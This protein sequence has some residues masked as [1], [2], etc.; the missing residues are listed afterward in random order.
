MA[1]LNHKPAG[2]ASS[3]PPAAPRL[4]RLFSSGLEGLRAVAVGFDVSDSTIER[5]IGEEITLGDLESAKPEDLKLIKISEEQA[6]KVFQALR[7]APKSAS[8]EPSLAP[9]GR[10]AARAR[11]FGIPERTIK[12]LE[13]R[14][15]D[16]VEVFDLKTRDLVKIGVKLGPAIRVA[17]AIE[18]MK[19]EDRSA[20]PGL[21]KIL[22]TARLEVKRYFDTLSRLGCSLE[23]L[24]RLPSHD[25]QTLFKTRAEIPRGHVIRLI[26]AVEDLQKEIAEEYFR[27]GDAYFFGV[28]HRTRDVSRGSTLLKFAA[29]LG[30]ACAQGTCREF[31]LWDRKKDSKRAAEC[32]LRG[33]EQGHTAAMNNIGCAYFGG[34]EG[35][36]EDKD[37]AFYWISKAVK[38]SNERDGLAG[39][40]ACYHYAVGVKEDHKAA[41]TYYKKAAEAG[42]A[43]AMAELGRC[44]QRGLGLRRKF[45]T[46]AAKWYQASADLG[47]TQGLL[48]LA[49]W[50]MNDEA[51]EDDME[52][53]FNLWLKA[54]EPDPVDPDGV[55]EACYQVGRCYQL[56]EG[57][58]RDMASAKKYYTQ[59]AKAGHEMAQSALEDLIEE[60]RIE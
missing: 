33:A 3:L 59:A 27:E 32:Y 56:G 60:T 7:N 17:K 2:H 36:E 15:V 20:A 23:S 40:A 43:A 22:E 11:E 29:E 35:L 26:R 46:D 9:L 52:T 47:C 42:D 24:I 44:Y 45:F 8:R 39:M 21:I 37:E 38:Q 19:S 51:T 28:N 54:T 50:Y 12:R 4:N 16:D 14:G 55:L 10:L 31:G 18:A 1:G 41:F 48:Y 58:E 57:I 25:L 30:H 53:A 5:L 13:E 34:Y 49:E 6:E